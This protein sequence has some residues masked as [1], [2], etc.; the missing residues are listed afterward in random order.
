MK[1]KLNFKSIVSLIMC[2]VV[3][4]SV[5][6]VAFAA[7]G[8][9][10]GHNNYTVTIEER[11]P[12]CELYGYTAQKECNVCKYVEKA[13][14]KPAIGH[15]YQPDFSKNN[16][17]GVTYKC[18]NCSD[19]YIKRHNWTYNLLPLDATCT[20]PGHTADRVCNDCGYH[21][22]SEAIPMVEHSMEVIS[23]DSD[24]HIVKCIT[25]SY[26]SSDEGHDIVFVFDKGYN[27][28]SES[29][30]G[31]KECSICGYVTQKDMTVVKGEHQ[32]VTVTSSREYRL[33]TCDDCGYSTIVALR[34]GKCNQ[35]LTADEYSINLPT[36]TDTGYLFYN[37]KTSD[38]AHSNV[39]TF[40]PTGHYLE[41]SY[42]VTLTP[43]CSRDGVK[44]KHCYRCDYSDD[45]SIPGTGHMF[46][47]L[48]PE[49]PATCTQD[50]LTIS[51][52]CN[53]CGLI[54]QQ[55]TIPATG[56]DIHDYQGQAFCYNCNK[57]MID[58]DGEAIECDCLCHNNDGLAK[59]VFKFLLFFFK[60]FKMKQTCDC[61]TVV[62][63]ELKSETIK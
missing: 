33:T 11:E 46:V 2:V 1:I 61:G 52:F 5:C 4:F 16:S 48:I 17:E 54:T 41:E 3:I 8:L 23:S 50:G 21:Q 49:E 39:I 44:S 63:Y 43:D 53:Y 30:K 32:N 51:G 37:C 29:A 20:Q 22:V 19:S 18:E 59:I 57:Y 15:N 27:C 31:H 10:C 62:H 45:I 40:D 13:Q 28:Y 9:A 56:H 38:C 6:P 47:V 60:L 36:C 34:C 26:V 58:S 55:V 25:C 35:T 24:S 14:Y 7:N 12:T 42:S